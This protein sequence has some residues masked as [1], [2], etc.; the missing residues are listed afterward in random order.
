VIRLRRRR[1]RAI[2]QETELAGA[3]CDTVEA[4]VDPVDDGMDAVDD[5]VD[6]D[7]GA[8]TDESGSDE[9]QADFSSASNKTGRRLTR[10]I[11]WTRLLA[12]VVLPV[13]V[14]LLA[15]AAAWLK[16]QDASMRMRD[17]IGQQTLQAAKDA[18][19]EI[20]SY[21][22]ESVEK[23][24][25]HAQTL[26]TGNFRDSYTG[27]TRDVVIPGA[28]QKH[29]SAVASVPAA[30]VVSVGDDHAVVVLCINQTTIVGNDAP[31][32]TTSSVRVTMDRVNGR[33]LVSAFD[34]I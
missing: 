3:S 13:V 5:G 33:W 32:S 9:D 20:L 14:L 17:P 16:W 24:L 31:T 1:H 28:Q 26:L 25:T 6:I 34:P 21:K 23:E 2:G 19:V 12:F 15:A 10:Q 4:D 18:A 8:R 30:A 27:L 29:I 22:P 11:S 7:E